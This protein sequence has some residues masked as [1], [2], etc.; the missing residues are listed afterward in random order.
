MGDLMRLPRELRDIVYQ[1]LL[2]RERSKFTKNSI[3][4]IRGRTRP[5]GRPTRQFGTDNLDNLTSGSYCIDIATCADIPALS[6][7]LTRRQLYSEAKEVFYQQNTFDTMNAENGYGSVLTRRAFL[8]DRPRAVLNDI[9]HL[10][11]LL[12]E[13]YHAPA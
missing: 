5:K 4:S 3:C 8:G 11:L 10:S 2:V 9:R 6:L 13:G 7:L 1:I 12:R